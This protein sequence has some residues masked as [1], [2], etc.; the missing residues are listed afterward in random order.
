MKHPIEI[1]LKHRQNLDCSCAASAMEIILK[2]HE[3][4]PLDDYRFQQEFGDTNI[5][6]EKKEELARLGIIAVE[7]RPPIDQAIENINAEIQ[8]GRFPLVS[9]PTF[10]DGNTI[11]CHVH[12]ALHMKG[13]LV[14]VDPAKSTDT[15][16]EYKQG[17][18]KVI[19]QLH[20]QWQIP[21]DGTLHYLRYTIRNSVS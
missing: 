11:W 13:E 2:C 21:N 19:E 17:L 15:N 10:R 12:I 18:P 6:F 5:G 16:I 3:L 9:L 4:I 14:F 20:N 7:G 1:L 8:Q